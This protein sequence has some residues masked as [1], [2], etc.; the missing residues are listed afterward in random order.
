M[1]VTTTFLL[2]AVAAALA[3]RLTALQRALR[4]LADAAESGTPFIAGDTGVLRGRHHLGRLHRVLSDLTA[5]HARSSRQEQG[6]F[7]QIEATL[8]NIKEAVLI[9]NADQRVVLANAAAAELLGPDKVAPGQRLESA[10]RGGPLLDHIYRTVQGASLP[11]EEF[12]LARGREPS[13]WI[14]LT[15]APISAGGT[16]GVKLYL[17]VLHDITRLK[18]LENIRKEFVANV[19]H[20]LRT[21]LTVILGFA[22]MLVEDGERLEPAER[23]RFLEKIR[24]NAERLAAL[25]ADLLTLSRLES[26]SPRFEAQPHSLRALIEDAAAEFADRLRPAGVALELDLRHATDELPLDPLK[27]SQVFHNLLDNCLRYA[28]GFSRVRIATLEQDGAVRVTVADNGCG[29]PA[30]DVPHVFERFYRVDKGRS[31][32]SGGTGLGLSI[33]KHIILLHG[34]TVA[35]ASEER[36]GTRIHFTL[37]TPPSKDARQDQ[38]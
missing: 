35:C 32:E 23:V 37:P 7:A 12:E 31:R 38:R 30:A 15:G 33:V 26:G 10:V 3:W 24:R 18:N 21:P 22:E 8:G 29:I 13:H 17:F 6:Y 25:V 14:E 36:A 27:I 9:I 34:G 11:R 2:A 5:R 16:E 20:E 28:K 19:S 4:D 1:W